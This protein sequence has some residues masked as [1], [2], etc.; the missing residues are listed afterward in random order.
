MFKLFLDKPLSFAFAY[1]GGLG[2]GGEGTLFVNG[3]KV[4]A[5]RIG[6]TQPFIF[7]GDEGADVGLD[8]GTLVTE[9]YREGDN[10]FTGKIEKVTVE[11]GPVGVAERP[12]I[13]HA[14]KEL[15]KK[16][17]LSD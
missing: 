15:A 5:G 10:T 1:D 2:Q 16:K 6:K 9:D 13:D 12:A 11:V 17:A 4:A 8:E 14:V 7:S 3:Q